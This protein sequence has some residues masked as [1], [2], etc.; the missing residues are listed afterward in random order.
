M[1]RSVIKTNEGDKD[2]K[3]AIVVKEVKP[4]LYKKPENNN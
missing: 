2:E 4:K 3:L 1:F